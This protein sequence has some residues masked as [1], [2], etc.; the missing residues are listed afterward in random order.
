MPTTPLPARLVRRINR[1]VPFLG[2]GIRVRY[3]DENFRRFEV[4]L[5]ERWYNRNLFGTHFGGCLYTMSDPFHVFIV[6]LNFGRGYIVWDKSAAIDFL[7]PARGTIVGIFEIDAARLA[8]MRDE[9]NSAGKGTFEFATELVDGS[10]EA[11]VRVRKT[12][13][14]RLKPAER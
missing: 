3:V 6:T 2:M 1:Y 13:Y 9:V 8:S 7:K 11:V 5:R 10:G 4:E 12:V 14:V